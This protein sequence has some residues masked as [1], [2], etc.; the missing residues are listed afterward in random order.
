MSQSNNNPVRGRV[1][2]TTILAVLLC[3]V[4]AFWFFS[5]KKPTGK[6]L[7]GVIMCDRESERWIRDGFHLQKLL[8]DVGCDVSL[9]FSEKPSEQVAEIHALIEREAKVLI[10]AA[11]DTYSLVDVLRKAKAKGIG[12]IA[13]DRLIQNTPNLDYY[14]SFDSTKVGEDMARYVVETLRPTPEKPVSVELIGG[15]VLDPNSTCLYEGVMRVLSPLLENKAVVVPS[16]K[17]ALEQVLLSDWSAQQAEK[18]MTHL[19]SADKAL[20]D[21]VICFSDTLTQGAISAISSKEFKYPLLTGQ[22]G[23]RAA[24]RSILE[25]KQSMT[26]FKDTRLLAQEAVSLALALLHNTPSG[27]T[28]SKNNGAADIP[29]RIAPVQRVTKDNYEDVLIKSG[30]YK[31]GLL[32]SE[33]P[34]GFVYPDSLIQDLILNMEY[35]TDENLTGKKIEGYDAPKA[36]LTTEAATA[37]QRAA[38][39]LRAKGYR[40]ILYDAYRPQRAVNHLLS[41]V[42]D[43]G[44]PGKKQFYPNLTKQDLLNMEYVNPLSSHTHGS[45]LDVGLASK[46]GTPIDMGSR[47][48]V[49]DDKTAYAP[50]T[51]TEPQKTV[52]TILR[53]A[54]TSAGFEPIESEWWH[55]QLKNQPYPN[56]Y[57][58][59][60]VR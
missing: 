22:D 14:V 36:I 32:A 31:P 5:Q 3:C 30:Y 4:A 16:G 58:D 25:D 23:A 9:S 48:G 29:S 47:F 52:R 43:D 12:V 39:D 59:F 27:E 24:I 38:D 37:L 53:N 60:S 40:I 10:I 11:N 26:V 51:I 44:L 54:M 7:I 13:Y 55:F 45:A 17:I 46:D 49:Y 18:R 20:P 34:E 50:G 42:N 28:V 15:A 35:A 19:L 21:A 57:F 33:L 2:W 1:L 41:W 6:P 56:A 8:V